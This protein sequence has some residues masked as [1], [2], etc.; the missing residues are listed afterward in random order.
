[1]PTTTARVIRVFLASPGDVTDE[2]AQARHLIKDDLPTSPFIKDK[3]WLKLI[4]WED[5]LSR[6]A[7]IGA[8][9]TSGKHPT[10]E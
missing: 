10:N 6:A 2:R 8:R 9:C 1:M 3:A 4:A 5:P 7:S